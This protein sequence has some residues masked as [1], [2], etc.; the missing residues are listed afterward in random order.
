MCVCVGLNRC[1]HADR[2]SQTGRGRQETP[3]Y[4]NS[5]LDTSVCRVGVNVNDEPMASRIRGS[6]PPHSETTKKKKGKQATELVIRRAKEK[7][8]ATD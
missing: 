6:T 4:V 7:K 3:I 2:T 8:K 1:S 5:S